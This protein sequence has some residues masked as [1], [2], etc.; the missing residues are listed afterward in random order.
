MW[1]R[2][3]HILTP[4]NSL[5][6]K[7][8]KWVWTDEHTKAF[9]TIKRVMSWETLLH[10]PDFKKP[11]EIHTD[12]SLH[13]IGAVIAQDNKPVAFWSR[14]LRDDQH[15]YTTTEQELLAIVEVRK[16]D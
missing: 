15:N 4:L 8:T 12:A 14:K 9:N 1:I 6:K 13:Q 7:E 3:S 16:E 11:F 10:Y 2:R 5:L